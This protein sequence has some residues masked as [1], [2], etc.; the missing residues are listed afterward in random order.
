M[1]SRAKEFWAQ[2]EAARKLVEENQSTSLADLLR[3]EFDMRDQQAADVL[4][5][6]TDSSNPGDPRTSAMRYWKDEQV[7]Q[8]EW[9]DGGAPYNYYEVTPDQWRN[10]SKV[11]S[12]GRAINRWL[13]G[14]PYGPS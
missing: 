8:V 7:V 3:D 14:H 11:K 5:Q 9:G 2:L 6:P 1:A 10:L 13:N 12:P 4:I